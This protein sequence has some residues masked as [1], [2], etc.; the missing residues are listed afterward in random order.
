M[1]TPE[2]EVIAI[3]GMSNKTDRYSYLAAQRLLKAG[4]KEIWGVHP[5]LTSIEDLSKVK[6]VAS[7]DEL[8]RNVHTLT[9]YIGAARLTPM[10]EKILQLKPKRIIMNP[11][12]ENQELTD[13]AREAGIET[14]EACTL[15][16][17]SQEIF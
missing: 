11:G 6:M 5:K 8:P 7:I 2:D 14:M 4:Y 15:V 9:L 16:L 17:L 13:K 12:T 1:N 10:I 3:L